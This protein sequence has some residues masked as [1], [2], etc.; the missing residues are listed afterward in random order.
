MID[1]VPLLRYIECISMTATKLRKELFT[2]LENVSKG[3][4]VEIDYK[5][6]TIKLVA[7]QSSSKLARAKRQHALLVD[8][9][10]IIG[11]DPELNREIEANLLRE[12]PKA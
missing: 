4:P 3:Q 10:S 2:V 6:S 5:G 1:N 12:W 7:A 11:S 9:E 8:P